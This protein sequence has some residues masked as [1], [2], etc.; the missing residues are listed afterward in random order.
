MAYL[1]EKRKK[2]DEIIAQKKFKLRSELLTN[3]EILKEWGLQNIM[4]EKAAEIYDL[5]E[6]IKGKFIDSLNGLEQ[7]VSESQ[8][9]LDAINIA[10]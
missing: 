2:A 7:A 9:L 1:A 10:D 5:S 3:I 4:D 6:S 8:K